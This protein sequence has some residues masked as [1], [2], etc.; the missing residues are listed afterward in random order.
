[1]LVGICVCPKKADERIRRQNGARVA[2]AAVD[3]VSVASDRCNCRMTVK[4][5][6]VSLSTDIGPNHPV[7]M[8]VHVD[9]AAGLSPQDRAA[10]AKG[11]TAERPRRD[12]PPPR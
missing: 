9:Y 7:D 8:I 11:L 4:G 10:L 6:V 5:G 2:F 1:M 12:G 3:S